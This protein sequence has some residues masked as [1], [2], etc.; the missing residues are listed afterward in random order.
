LNGISEGADVAGDHAL[1]LFKVIFVHFNLYYRVPL[2]S[3][4]FGEQFPRI[5][6]LVP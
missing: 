6:D 1:D 3:L 2:S 5:F 4:G